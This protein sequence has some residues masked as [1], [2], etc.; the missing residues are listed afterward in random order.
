[1]SK[2]PKSEPKV[3][4]MLPN[5]PQKIPVF[6]RLFY[7]GTPCTP[8]IGPWPGFTYYAAPG[9]YYGARQGLYYVT[10]ERPRRLPKLK[11]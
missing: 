8:Y 7:I 5:A 3:T 6:Y 4:K 10:P 1:M 2:K 11:P 9:L